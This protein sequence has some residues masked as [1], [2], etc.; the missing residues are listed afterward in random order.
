[1]QIRR[2]TWA[3]KFFGMKD[4]RIKKFHLWCCQLLNFGDLTVSHQI[5]IDIDKWVQ[6]HCLLFGWA[7]VE[8]WVVTLVAAGQLVLILVDLLG[9]QLGLAQQKT[10]LLV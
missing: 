5:M 4:V 3:R 6:I 7:D 10:G 9:A 1:M 8:D 2:I